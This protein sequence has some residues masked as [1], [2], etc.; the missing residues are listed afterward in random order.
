MSESVNLTLEDLREIC[1]YAGRDR[2]A[3]FLEPLNAAMGEF[4]IARRLPAL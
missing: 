3:L 4:G 1:P 2:L